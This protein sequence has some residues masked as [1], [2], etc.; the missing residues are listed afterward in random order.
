MR[1]FL[2]LS[3][4]TWTRL[5]HCSGS[6]EGARSGDRAYAYMHT[7]SKVMTKEAFDV[8]W[9]KVGQPCSA[10]IRHTGFCHAEQTSISADQLFG[11]LRCVMVT[12]QPCNCSGVP[13][14]HC[15]CRILQ[16]C[17]QTSFACD[18]SLCDG[19]ICSF[20]CRASGID[21]L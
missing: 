12:Y 9:C 14:I 20:S 7:Y 19:G 4:T 10:L 16:G 13:H 1:Y 11:R 21:A 2:G 5:V 15:C 3:R 17:N 8:V 6:V 18:G